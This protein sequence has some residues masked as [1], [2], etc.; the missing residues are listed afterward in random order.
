MNYSAAVP[1]PSGSGLND[2]ASVLIGDI[3]FDDLS[4]EKRTTQLKTVD[5]VERFTLSENLSE[6]EK[7]VHLLSQNGT[8]TQRLSIDL[9]SL[10]KTNPEDFYNKVTPAIIE[11]I[12][13]HCSRELHHH[14]VQGIIKI[15][16]SNSH[17]SRLINSRLIP[18]LKNCLTLA[19]TQTAEIWLPVLE[20]LIPLARPELIK[21]E[22]FT[23]I[24]TE[25][26]PLSK[27]VDYRKIAASAVGYFTQTSGNSLKIEQIIPILRAFCNDIDARV[28][29]AITVSLEFILKVTNEKNDT[30]SNIS[31][32]SEVKIVEFCIDL[33]RDESPDVQTAAINVCVDVSEKISSNGKIEQMV[34]SFTSI[35]QVSKN[36]QVLNSLS[37]GVPRLM[38]KYHEITGLNSIVEHLFRTNEMETVNGV[39]AVFY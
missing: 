5:E 32:N 33:L 10:C 3:D 19:D 26:S 23:A 4:L 28:R 36:T 9:L 15:L 24:I 21:N 29:C 13:L 7:A 16:K 12:K 39:T 30:V 11:L 8:D 38:A 6:T 20:Y 37:Y 25:F 31:N 22:L 17:S 35:S 34:N 1:L 18:L 2:L 14:F 27:P